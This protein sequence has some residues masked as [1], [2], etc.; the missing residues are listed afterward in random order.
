[1]G[2]IY[3]NSFT[4][5]SMKYTKPT[6]V[7]LPRKPQTERYGDG[8]RMLCAVSFYSAV[9]LK[10]VIHVRFDV[11]AERF[12]QSILHAHTPIDRPLATSTEGFASYIRRIGCDDIPLIQPAAYRNVERYAARGIGIKTPFAPNAIG[13]A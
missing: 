10:I 2:Q 5:P 7:L 13:Q 3:D 8:K 4:L 11:E 6:T 12:K 9:V 1:M